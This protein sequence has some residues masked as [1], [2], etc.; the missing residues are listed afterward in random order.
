MLH[1]SCGECGERRL[2][3]RNAVCTHSASPLGVSSS[4]SGTPGTAAPGPGPRTAAPRASLRRA[5]SPPPAARR[6]VASKRAPGISGS[7]VSR[8]RSESALSNEALG[9][10]GSGAGVARAW[11][12]RGAGYGH[13]FGLGWRGRGVGVARAFPVPPGQFW[14]SAGGPS[15][16]AHV[17]QRQQGGEQVRL[18]GGGGRPAVSG[19]L[20]WDNYFFGGRERGVHWDYCFFVGSGADTAGLGP[21]TVYTV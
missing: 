8:E 1:S 5:A 13:F 14:G 19:G 9:E 15:A 17:P 21:G 4:N 6:L 16:A 2:R 3:R 10:Q 12:G 11:R 18:T 20:H 7:P